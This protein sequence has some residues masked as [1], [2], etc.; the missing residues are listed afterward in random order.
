[1]MRYA[2]TKYQ[3]RKP[4]T[5]EIRPLLEFIVAGGLATAVKAGLELLG[6]HVGDP[7]R[8]LLRL[9]EA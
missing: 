7:R 8:P 5:A 3:Q 4:F 1:M 9:D 6:V 2:R